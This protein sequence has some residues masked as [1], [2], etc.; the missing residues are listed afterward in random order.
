M[1][2]T[3]DRGYDGYRA[4]PECSNGP[5]NIVSS[6]SSRPENYV[7]SIIYTH[8]QVPGCREAMRAAY[9]ANRFPGQHS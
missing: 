1:V 9:Q 4:R 6:N 8:E 2:S 5:F 3:K 7:L